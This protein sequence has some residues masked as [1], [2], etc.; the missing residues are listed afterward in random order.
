M[1]AGEE[2][3]VTEPKSTITGR[4]QRRSEPARSRGQVRR[5]TVRSTIS[6][7]TCSRTSLVL[8][9]VTRRGIDR[10]RL[11]GVE[12]PPAPAGV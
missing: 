11:R 4:L 10:K 5:R 12:N 6:E 7:S 9:G 3:N 1:S 2:A 8:E